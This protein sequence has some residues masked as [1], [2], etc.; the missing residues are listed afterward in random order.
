M[1][2]KQK[3][4]KT[5]ILLVPPDILKIH[6][7][8]ALGVD[9]MFVNKVPFLITISRNIHFETVEELPN[10][11][12]QTVKAKLQSVIAIYAHRGFNVST[13]LADGE[14]EPMRPWFPLLNTCAENEHVPEIERFI[15]TIKNSTRSIYQMLLFTRIPRLI[16]MRL[17]KTA[18][19]WSNAFPSAD[20]V[21]S[22]HSPRRLIAGYEVSYKK[23]A[24]I[25]FGTHVQT[26][27]NHANDMSQRTI[28]AICLG[29]TGNQQGG[30][31]F[32]S[33]TSGSMI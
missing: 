14:F 21:S 8:V 12:L 3:H 25:K 33:L 11:K 2:K 4:V 10:R 17:V 23:H 18:V 24:V 15:R 27:E 5:S 32:M 13:I 20:G 7:E 28:G 1:H 9:I 6:K 31:W 30:H 26:H 19:F 22:A 16:A 29:P